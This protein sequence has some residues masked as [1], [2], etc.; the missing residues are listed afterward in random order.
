MFIVLY[1]FFKKSDLIGLKLSCIGL[2]D[3][4]LF[5]CL[6]QVLEFEI[7]GMSFQNRLALSKCEEKPHH[8]FDVSVEI[9]SDCLHWNFYN[10][11]SRHA[12]HFA[13]NLLLLSCFSVK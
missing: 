4:N 7:R 6:N 8:V 5:E 3:K 12:L 9:P 13:C 2:L 10:F 11:A 1:H